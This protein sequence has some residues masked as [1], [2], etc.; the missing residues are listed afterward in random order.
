MS[1]STI[2]EMHGEAY[3]RR[4]ERDVLRKFLASPKAS[5]GAVLATGGSIVNDPDTYEL[6]KQRAITVW[7][8]ARARDHWDRVVAQGDVRPMRGRANAMSELKALLKTRKP[9]YEQARHVIDTS[10][11]SLDDAVERVAATSRPTTTKT[12]TDNEV[13]S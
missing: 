2:F 4:L 10:S 5:K 9:L 1:L 3:F 8:K 6:L 13:R 11:L 12:K 7:L